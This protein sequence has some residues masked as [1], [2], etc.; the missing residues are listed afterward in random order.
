MRS[1]ED[2]FKNMSEAE[3][4]TL[5]IIIKGDVQGSVEAL[6]QAMD[7]ITEE[8]LE[9]ERAVAVN[10]IHSAVGAVTESDIMLADT[11]SAVVICFNV[12]PEAK[13]KAL[14]DRS[15]IDIKTYRVI[16]DV[17]DDI[18][19]ALIGM[20]EPVYREE[21]LGTAEV[22]DTF[23]ITGVGTI[24][25]CFVTE[26]RIQRSAKMRLI[27]ENI[28][29]YEGSVSSLKRMK[30]DVKEVV[31]GY[32]CGIGLQNYNDIKAGD[33]IEAFLLVEEEIK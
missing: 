17:I 21:Y 18:E 12:R 31:L 25:G 16:Y 32:E 15:G 9:K 2:M 10:V 23:R 28:V 4:K 27:R 1:L 22:R 8:M 26:G 5:N 20:L 33:L 30:D 14:A 11:A 3:K 13:A 6:K 7:K 19:K 24:A 29:I